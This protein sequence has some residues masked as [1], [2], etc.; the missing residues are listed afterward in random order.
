VLANE[1]LMPAVRIPARSALFASAAA[2]RVP[3]A[4]SDPDS[5]P[6]IAYYQLANQLT[7]VSA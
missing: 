7:V 2:R 5:S 4:V 6:A 1:D 3:L